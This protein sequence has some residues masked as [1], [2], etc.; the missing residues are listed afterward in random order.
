MGNGE[1]ICVNKVAGRRAALAWRTE[2]AR[3]AQHKDAQVV[4]AQVHRPAGAAEIVEAF[5]ATPFSGGEWHARRIRLIS[6]FEATGDAP[7]M[8]AG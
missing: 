7:P 6:D 5:L 2:T 3:L 4:G 1:Q 8:S